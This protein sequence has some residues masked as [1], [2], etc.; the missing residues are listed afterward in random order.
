MKNCLTA[1]CLTVMLI[2]VLPRPAHATA[3]MPDTPAAYT[4]AA[5]WTRADGDRILAA[6]DRIAAMDAHMA[7]AVHGDIRNV[8]DSIGGPALRAFVTEAAVRPDLYIKGKKITPAFAEELRKNSTARIREENPVAF[9]IVTERANIRVFPT[10]VQAFETPA[11]THFDAWQCSAVDPATPVRVYVYDGTGNFCYVRAPGYRGWIP[12]RQIALTDRGTWEKFVQ[13]AS[14][15]VV[16]G[17]LLTLPAG[18]A[19]QVYQMGAAIPTENGS[20]LLPARDESGD[21]RIIREKPYY[22]AS[23]HKGYLPYTANNI[24][25]MAFRHL[26]APYGWG[27]LEGS[28]D[29]SAFTGDV[30]RS[31]GIELPRDADVQGEVLPYRADLEGSVED[32]CALLRQFP[33]GTLL[34]TPTHVLMYLGTDDAGVPCVLQAMS[35]YY[36]FDGG[37]RQKHYLRRVIASTVLFPSFAGTPYIESVQSFGAVCGK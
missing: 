3:Q 18:D 11:D 22:N 10:E 24:I 36:T 34:T 12:S 1:L 4:S 29:C 19:R 14:P 27:G 21:L 8:K 15:A 6:P 37:A 26:G 20:L 2:S 32:R 25:A 35:S 16:T 23:L 5:A 31:M 7:E 13:P 30:Y 17:R 9:A 28:V 33:V